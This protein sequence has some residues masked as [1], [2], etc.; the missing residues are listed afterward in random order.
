MKSYSGLIS[1]VYA[2]TT[3]LLNGPVSKREPLRGEKQLNGAVSSHPSVLRPQPT[4]P[5]DNRS[6]SSGPKWS[7]AHIC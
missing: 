7:R 1:R 2:P 4:P 5:R 6:D 3:C